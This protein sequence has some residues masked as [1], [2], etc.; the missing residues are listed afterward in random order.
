MTAGEVLV[1]GAAHKNHFA[2]ANVFESL[3]QAVRGAEATKPA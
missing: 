3:E 2:F 1:A